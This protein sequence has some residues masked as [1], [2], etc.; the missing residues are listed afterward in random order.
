VAYGRTV[1]K[2]VL[3]LRVRPL[4]EDRKPRWG[5]AFLRS[6]VMGLGYLVGGWLFLLLDGLWPL[7]DKPWQ[8]AIHDKAARTV[9]VPR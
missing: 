4:A 5:E 8:Q 1:G 6:G 3:G 9:V 7:W 2:R